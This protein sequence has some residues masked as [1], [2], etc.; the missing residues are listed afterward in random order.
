MSAD[1]MSIPQAQT[2][3]PETARLVLRQWR[4]EDREP[5]VA[6]SSDPIVMEFLTSQRDPATILS[7]IDAWSADISRRGWG[8]WAAELKQTRELIGFVGL[9]V[10]AEGH[11][12][13]PS[14]ELGWRLGRKHWGNGYATE[15]GR[16]C[17]KI[18]FE[19]LEL[20]EVIATTARGNVRSSAVMTR[21]RMRGPETTFEHPGVPI[22]SPNRRHVLYRISRSEWQGHDA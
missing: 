9:S 18:A 15:G 8:F 16:A 17:L 22:D 14:V 13:L 2:I 11:P 7:R 1:L 3:E 10:P 5:F 20:P 4:A 19:V 6:I 21:L 12:F